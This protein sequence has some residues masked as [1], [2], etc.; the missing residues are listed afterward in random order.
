MTINSILN[1]LESI[2]QKLRVSCMTRGMGKSLH[3]IFQ[4]AMQMRISD[5]DKA[6]IF[7]R[8]THQHKMK[9]L[10]E[11]FEILS[12][13]TSVDVFTSDTWLDESTT[14]TKKKQ[15]IEPKTV[16]HHT[17]P[18]LIINISPNQVI[19]HLPEPE[20]KVTSFRGKIDPEIAKMTAHIL[21]SDGFVREGAR[22]SNY[23]LRNN[24][25]VAEVQGSS[26]FCKMV[27][28][29]AEQTPSILSPSNLRS[30]RHVNKTLC[31]TLI[32]KR[33]GHVF[34]QSKILNVG[35]KIVSMEGFS[36]TFGATM[37][38]DMFDQFASLRID[39]VSKEMHDSINESLSKAIWHDNLTE[40]K[41]S[42]IHGLIHDPSYSY[43]VCIGSGYVW[44]STWAI[45][46]C[47]KYGDFLFYCNR[48][49]GCAGKPGVTIL[50]IN[51]K[52]N[53]THELL[54]KIA[55]RLTVTGAEY[56][57][58]EKIQ[59]DLWAERIDYIPMKAQKVGNC[60][61][62]SEKAKIFS[63][64]L[65]D[66]ARK[67]FEKNIELTKRQWPTPFSSSMVQ[68]AKQIYKEF[69][70]FDKEA[71]LED[72]L[73][74][75]EGLNLNSISDDDDKYSKAHLTV[76]A[77]IKD[78]ALKRLEKNKINPEL[79]NRAVNLINSTV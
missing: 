24:Q 56:A 27:L 50:K 33:I 1:Q 34:N 8:W 48:G 55:S 78:W 52:K 53:I 68:N 51:N 74:S 23:E 18:P 40:T 44:H 7:C 62:A 45:F 61:Y 54:K 69:S 3:K 59:I 15:C 13:Y 6:E 75:L 41:L 20:K 5:E 65:I 4:Q 49:A 2:Q 29:Y 72:F 71:V 58:L 10:N 11:V 31:D 14:H 21:K 37:L 26:A 16:P 30:Q 63:L 22:D 73:Q 9:D 28:Q 32:F 43:P 76:A 36:E 57:N 42:E 79:L 70:K 67:H 25:T 19:E 60:V 66:V 12:K 17:F 47:T 77:C 38:R 39:L 35:N 64:L 46:F